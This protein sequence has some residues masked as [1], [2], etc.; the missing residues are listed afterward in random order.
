MRVSISYR[1]GKN[2]EENECKKHL[3]ELEGKEKM[4]VLSETTR[5]ALTSTGAMVLPLGIV[6]GLIIAAIGARCDSMCLTIVGAVTV[7]AA[8]IFVFVYLKKPYLE[9]KAVISDNYSA[10]E[11]Y[12]KYDV[13]GHDGK[14]WILE[15]KERQ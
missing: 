8:I 12:E 6:L 4:T 2:H 15:E 7:L 1:S 11:L 9:F 13:V 5:Y 10:T 3:S 14:I